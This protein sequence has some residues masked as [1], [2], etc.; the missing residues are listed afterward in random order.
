LTPGPEPEKLAIND[1]QDGVY[2]TPA[3]AVGTVCARTHSAL[4]AFGKK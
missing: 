1:M 2:A 3:G 4:F